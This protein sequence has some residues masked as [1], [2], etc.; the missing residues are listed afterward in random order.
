MK[1]SEANEILNILLAAFH[2]ETMEQPT[3][4][5][6]VE[7]LEPYDAEVA[8]KV[9]LRWATGEDRFPTINQFRHF[10]RAAK[11]VLSQN[12]NPVVAT[13]QYGLPVAGAPEWV[14]RWKRARAEGAAIE[15]L[16]K[17]LAQGD[18]RVFPEQI[19]DGPKY[20]DDPRYTLAEADEIGIMPET[21]WVRPSS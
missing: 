14:G 15:D 7:I 19:V 18:W 1:T 2:R 13:D 20:H 17:R 9:A 16:K 3:I 21:A 6:W 8:T 10:Y 11:G 5:L 12:H 4:D